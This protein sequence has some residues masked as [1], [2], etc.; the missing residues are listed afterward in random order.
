MKC[1]CVHACVRTLAR[2]SQRRTSG[3][4]LHHS[5]LYSLETDFPSEP[6]ARSTPVTLLS[7]TPTALGLQMHAPMPSLLPEC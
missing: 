4:L 1:A 6:G 2:E 7:S 5:I 3:A